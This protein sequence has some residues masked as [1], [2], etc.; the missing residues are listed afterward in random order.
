MTSL[1]ANTPFDFINILFLG[2]DSSTFN[3]Q[4]ATGAGVSAS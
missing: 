3:V 2:K 1:Y 4:Y